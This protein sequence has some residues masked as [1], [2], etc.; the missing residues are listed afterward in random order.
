VHLAR[1]AALLL[2][3][4]LVQCPIVREPQAGEDAV[5]GG[6]DNLRVLVSVPGD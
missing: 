6:V 3:P 4:R 1:A 2:R 5:R